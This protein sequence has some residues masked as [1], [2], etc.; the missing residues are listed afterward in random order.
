MTAEMNSTDLPDLTERI[1]A[2]F[3]SRDSG[4]SA[5][6]ATLSDADRDLLRAELAEGMTADKAEKVSRLLERPF[7]A[8]VEIAKIECQLNRPVDLGRRKVRRPKL[9]VRLRDS[10]DDITSELKA[11]ITCM[12]EVCALIEGNPVLERLVTP[13]LEERL[14]ARIVD[15]LRNAPKDA[16]EHLLDVLEVLR[17]AISAGITTGPVA[18]SLDFLAQAVVVAIAQVTGRVPGRTWIEEQVEETGPG[19]EACRVLARALNTALPEDCRRNPPPDMAKAF[20]RAI[21]DIRPE[22]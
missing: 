2:R 21:K 1:L 16:A 3:V 9:G 11:G 18:P 20:R 4:W 17:D 22:A 13:L 10:I 7:S 14:S 19:L 12:A 5:D 15:P 6:R 8:A